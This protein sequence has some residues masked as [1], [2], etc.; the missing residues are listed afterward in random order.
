[1]DNFW[2]MVLL[3]VL[4]GIGWAFAYANKLWK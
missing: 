2:Q 4:L 1:M 3:G